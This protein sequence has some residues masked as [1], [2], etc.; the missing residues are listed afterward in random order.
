MTVLS[1]LGIGIAFVIAVGLLVFAG[2]MLGW[3]AAGGHRAVAPTR[4]RVGGRTPVRTGGS[5]DD[6]SRL[7]PRDRR[8]ELHE[9]FRRTRARDAPR[10][11]GKE[12]LRPDGRKGDRGS[13]ADQA[14]PL[15]GLERARQGGDGRRLPRQ[16]PGHRPDGRD[17]DDP[18]LQHG[19]RRLRVAGVPGALHPRGP[20][21]RHPVP[22]QHRHDPRHRRRPRDADVVHRDGVHRGEEPEVAPRRE[23]AR[24]PTTRSPT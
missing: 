7:T 10:S 17:Q 18:G 20:D 13:A 22:P 2:V 14:R 16:G 5:S 9:L 12:L 19:R 23:G 15:R 11:K 8:L 24:S 4:P 1:C 6:G 3:A 21:R